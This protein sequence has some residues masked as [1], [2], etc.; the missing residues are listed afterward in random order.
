M[1]KQGGKMDTNKPNWLQWTT[2]VGVVVMLL[3]GFLYLPG[4]I[5]NAV[6]VVVD[7]KVSEIDI[8]EIP[9]AQEIDVDALAE[10]ILAGLNTEKI[11]RVCDLTE[12][13][14][15]Q[16]DVNNFMRNLAVDVVMDE[17]IERDNKILFNGIK[18]LVDI[19][20][21]ED[22]YNPVTVQNHFGRNPITVNQEDYD[23]LYDANDD[24][25][26]T[27]E[28]VIKVDYFD[29]EDNENRTRWFKVTATISDVE[30]G[31]AKGDVVINSVERVSEH[32]EFD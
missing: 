28:F 18:D 31:I 16:W 21:R 14:D 19:N 24:T 25:V 29:D 10:D 11:D 9:A 22:I 1:P 20:E 26:V 5:G 7:E 13:C 23:S 8:P 6:G 4:A 15:G 17:L 12:G 32:F 2:L 27:A 3:G 30:D